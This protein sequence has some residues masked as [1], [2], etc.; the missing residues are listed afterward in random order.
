MA[1]S[2]KHRQCEC[3]DRYDGHPMA[4]HDCMQDHLMKLEGEDP[5]VTCKRAPGRCTNVERLRTLYRVDMEDHSG[6]AFCGHCASDA[7][8]SG[9][10][11]GR[12]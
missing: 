4:P 1:G 12:R 2:V 7:E 10:F 3:E 8:D 5:G 11:T 9:L 6:V